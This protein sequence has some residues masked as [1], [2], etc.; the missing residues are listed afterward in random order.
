MTSDLT[1]LARQY[2]ARAEECRERASAAVTE[3]RRQS[4]LQ[5]AETAQ[6]A[7]MPQQAS[8]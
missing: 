2:R 7:T 1:D 6:M 4:L 3:E 5:I 8:A